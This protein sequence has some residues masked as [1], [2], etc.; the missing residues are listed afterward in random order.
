MEERN[1]VVFELII[2]SRSMTAIQYTVE[3]QLKE[4]M[5]SEDRAL[6]QQI[7]GLNSIN[8]IW[9]ICHNRL[10]NWHLK[11]AGKIRQFLETKRGRHS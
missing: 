10:S 1:N 2:G 4:P 9:I 8:E 5:D 7:Q 11:C 3:D 6:M